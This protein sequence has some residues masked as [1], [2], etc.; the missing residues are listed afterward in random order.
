MLLTLA[1]LLLVP[2]PSVPSAE[3]SR[4]ERR[5]LERAAREPSPSARRRAVAGLAELDDEAGW[6]A[7]IEALADREP[8]VADEAQLALRRVR[9]P[10]VLRRLQGR[11][12]LASRDPWV[13][14]RVAEALGRCE[15]ELEAWPLVTA[16]DADD[17]ELARLC[18]RSIERL[19]RAGRLAGD[20]ERLERG[21]RTA[22][23]RQR[24]GEVRA[25]ALSA[26][27]AVTSLE[28]EPTAELV[29]EALGDGDAS[30]RCAAL[31]A[32][33]SSPAT[34]RGTL[35]AAARRLAADPATA[36]RLQAVEALETAGT[37]GALLALIDRLEPEPRPRVR[38]RVLAAL[39]GMTGY[40]HRLDPRPWRHLAQGLPDGWTARA[41]RPPE[42]GAA[43]E[44]TVAFGGL[45]ILSDRVAFLIDCSGS[46]WKGRV[47]DR[48][49]K[50]IADARLRAAL[51]ALPESAAFNVIPY[52]GEPL[53]WRDG[54]VPAERRNVRD[55]LDSFERCNASG[56]GN[57]WDAALL[58]L[59]DPLVDTLVVLTDG[60]PTGGPH[61][62][63]DLLFE[64]LL[65]RNRYRRVAIDSLLVDASPTLQRRWRELAR[66]TGGRSLAMEA[67]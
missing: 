8:E 32:L 64:L 22:F 35:A 44:R 4:A 16:V 40:R 38:F 55:A 7:V 20:R 12:G 51:E 57:F 25:S 30:V 28:P 60:A 1:A 39:Q 61:W 13:R 34:E 47:G 33:A 6:T 18:L 54:L 37:K 58:A 24:E 2:L 65:E 50:E 31:A 52:T 19:A 41:A 5:E 17:P 11:E 14:R 29:R 43:G 63:L 26:L 59:D 66:A 48:T 27:V 56:K 3:V 53:P 62:N 23:A 9:D 45:P 10:A 15:V 42:T 49:R 46:L 67:E 21:L 36:V